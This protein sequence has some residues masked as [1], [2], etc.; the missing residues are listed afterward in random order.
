MSKFRNDGFSLEWDGLTEFID[1]LE[2]IQKKHESIIS[3]EMNDFGRHLEGATRKLIP[4]DHGDLEDSVNHDVQRRGMS[5]W[6][7]TVGSS[8]P[9]ALRRHEEPYRMGTY[10][11]LP[12]D[13][14]FYV[15]GRGRGT[16]GKPN[17]RGFEPGRKYLTNAILAV[18]ADYNKMNQRVLSLIMGLK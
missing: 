12:G 2:D 8:M 15:D 10:E 14:G 6:A 17:Y 5:T 3:R 7:L 18:D 9:Y 13:G 11:K 1:E 16:R 4:H